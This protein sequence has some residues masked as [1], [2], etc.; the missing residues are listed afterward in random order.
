[1]IAQI[2]HDVTYVDQSFICDILAGLL[3]TVKQVDI[4]IATIDSL[5]SM[6]GTGSQGNEAVHALVLDTIGH[7]VVRRAAALGE[8]QPMSGEDWRN[9]ESSKKLPKVYVDGSLSAFP[10]I[11]ELL[12]KATGRWKEDTPL[13]RECVSRVLIP[14][15]E[16]VFVTGLNQIIHQLKKAA[17]KRTVGLQT[18]FP[19][20][21]SHKPDPTEEPSDAAIDAFAVD[22]FIGNDVLYHEPWPDVKSSIMGTFEGQNYVRAALALAATVP[23]DR[24]R[25]SLAKILRL[26]F[27]DDMVRRASGRLSA[28]VLN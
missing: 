16:H 23:V 15:A 4:Q 14:V 18:F 2:L 25:L 19:R 5:V 9:A 6:L 26:E 28:M 8:K 22:E 11:L 12:V 17:A 24:M 3:T 20:T 1:M 21:G 13:R 10:P 27:A 7:H